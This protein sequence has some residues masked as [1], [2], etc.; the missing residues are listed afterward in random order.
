MN[1]HTISNVLVPCSEFL[2]LRGCFNKWVSRLNWPYNPSSGVQGSDFFSIISRFSK[3]QLICSHSSF[4][5]GAPL[6]SETAPSEMKINIV[7]RTIEK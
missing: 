4:K 1:I 2:N 5:S 7:Y 3:E 6:S